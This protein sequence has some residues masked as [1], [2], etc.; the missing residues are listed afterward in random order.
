M[1]KL[2][3]ALRASALYPIADFFIPSFLSQ[4]LESSLIAK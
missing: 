1:K 2:M 3:R 4:N